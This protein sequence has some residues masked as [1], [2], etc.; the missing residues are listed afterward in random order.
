MHIKDLIIKKFDCK[1]KENSMQ[2]RYRRRRLWRGKG[3]LQQSSVMWGREA[4]IRKSR[5]HRLRR[6]KE[7]SPMP[8]G[9]REELSP[10][11]KWEMWPLEREK[12]IS[13]ER[14]FIIDWGEKGD[15][16]G[17][18]WAASTRQ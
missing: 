17:V 1:P 3:C 8:T 10:T 9:E 4:S 18:D 2:R 7:M 6:E 5:C 13:G 14:R 12:E 11:E 16:A 15:I